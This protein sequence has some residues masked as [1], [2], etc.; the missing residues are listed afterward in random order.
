LLAPLVIRIFQLRH[1][2]LIARRCRFEV[3]NR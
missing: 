2:P 3:E 1:N